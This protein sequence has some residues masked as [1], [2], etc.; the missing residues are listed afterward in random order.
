MAQQYRVRRDLPN[1]DYVQVKATDLPE[2]KRVMRSIYDKWRDLRDPK[3]SEEEPFDVELT[4]GGKLLEV[5]QGPRLVDRYI[6]E[7]A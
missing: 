5:Y 2:C 6:I 1:N 3:W 4:N 7:K